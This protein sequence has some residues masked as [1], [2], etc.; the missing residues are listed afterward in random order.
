MAMVYVPSIEGKNGAFESVEYCMREV[1]KGW[2]MRYVHAN[3]ASVFFMCVIYAYRKR[4]V[5]WII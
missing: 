2:M 4:D 1:E 5:L 3:G